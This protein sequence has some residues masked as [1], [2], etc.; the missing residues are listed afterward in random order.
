LSFNHCLQVLTALKNRN[1]YI[2]L[3]RVGARKLILGRKSMRRVVLL[4][5]LLAPALAAATPLQMVNVQRSLP[6]VVEDIAV[7]MTRGL[8][9]RMQAWAPPPPDLRVLTTEPVARAE[10]SGFGWR[11]DPIRKRPK[12]HHGTDYRGK[13][14]TPVLA[15]GGGTVVVAGRRGGYGNVVFVDHGGGIVTRYAHL[16]RIET[17]LGA[18]IEA[19]DR[20]GQIGSTGRTTGPHLH[21]E[22]RLGG[23]SVDPNTAVAELMR[24]SQ[25][26]GRLAAFALAPELQS[27]ARDA[28][29]PKNRRARQAADQRPE[30][31]NAPSRPRALW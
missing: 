30:R 18:T 5:A 19:G 12:F 2:D 28:H 20:I 6:D 16:R 10:S 1:A 3:G 8:I 17:K 7:G 13:S 14:G 29:D 4:A 21:F 31:A 9:Q 11:D 23:R 22:V 24:E 26:A 27:R 25:A 15:A